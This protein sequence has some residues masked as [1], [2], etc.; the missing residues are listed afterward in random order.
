MQKASD[1]P[2]TFSP[3]LLPINP[4]NSLEVNEYGTLIYVLDI[5]PRVHSRP[6]DASV[7]CLVKGSSLDRM[8]ERTTCRGQTYVAENHGC[9]P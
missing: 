7:V 8:L 5:S 3:R 9:R 6:G 1:N 2:R 4:V